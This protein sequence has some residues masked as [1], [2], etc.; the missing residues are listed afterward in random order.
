MMNIRKISK[1]QVWVIVLGLIVGLALVCQPIASHFFDSSLCQVEQNAHED[2]A[3]KEAPDTKISAF[4][5]VT[6][7]QQVATTIADLFILDEII[8]D[9]DRDNGYDITFVEKIPG[10]LVR[11]L[12]NFII[13]PN[14]P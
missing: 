4:N 6:P 9:E 11:V 12:F 5:A 10:K 13:S 14:A 2:S 1:Y 3:E 8:L 7:A